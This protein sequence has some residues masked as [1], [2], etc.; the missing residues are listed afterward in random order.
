MRKIAKIEKES[1]DGGGEEG[2]GGTGDLQ[3]LLGL[4]ALLVRRQ[5][6]EGRRRQACRIYFTN[7]YLN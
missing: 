2:E 7:I 1:E 4:E 5:V 3:R 6:P